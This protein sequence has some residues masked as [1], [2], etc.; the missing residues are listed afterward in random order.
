[1]DLAGK[2][3]D[4]RRLD[5]HTG[6][7]KLGA[8]KVSHNLDGL[9]IYGS[10][11]KYLNGENV[12]P[13]VRAGVK[14]AIEKLENEL[15]VDLS[16]AIV[17]MVEVGK[18]F[19]LK[20]P[21]GEYLRLFGDHPRYRKCVT[22][23]AG[24]VETVLYDLPKSSYQFQGYDKTK[25]MRAK[26]KAMPELFV[27]CKVLRLEWRCRRRRGL[28][29]RFGRD[30]TCHELFEYETYYKLKAC[31]WAAYKAVEKLGREVFVDKTKP[32]TPSLLQRLMAEAHRQHHNDNYND[33]LGAY[34]DYGL[35][36]KKNV[37]RIRAENRRRGRDYSMSDKNPLIEELDSFVEMAAVRGA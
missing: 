33:Y 4:Y 3:R 13:L 2:L 36:T 29:G 6:S 21:P 24:T 5:T 26:R 25:E 31:F 23:K 9:T 19:I 8:L 17:S 28:Q 32:L 20:H 27:G 10:L 11:P 34:I 15:A 30:I 35:L 37:E 12:T 1:M 14:A 16:Q 22:T 18:T 7:G